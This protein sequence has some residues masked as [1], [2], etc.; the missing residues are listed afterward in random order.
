MERGPRTIV[1]EPAVMLIFIFQFEANWHDAL[2]QLGIRSLPSWKANFIGA[3][4]VLLMEKVF[5]GALEINYLD[6][7]AHAD[8]LFHD[9]KQLGMMHLFNCE[10]ARFPLGK[11]ILLEQILCY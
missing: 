10:F 2:V 11:Q 3:T 1:K 8:F 5:M 6:L 4:I 9:L 7:N